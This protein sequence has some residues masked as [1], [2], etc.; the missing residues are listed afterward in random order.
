MDPTKTKV[1]GVSVFAVTAAGRYK[2]AA[3]APKGA[4]QRREA[5]PEAGKQSRLKRAIFKSGLL[6]DFHFFAP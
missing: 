2:G 6:P 5:P 1:S 3:G 4:A